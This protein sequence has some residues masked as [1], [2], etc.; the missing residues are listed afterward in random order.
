MAST[1]L[2]TT[3]GTNQNASRPTTSRKKSIVKAEDI[4]KFA[5]DES[6]IV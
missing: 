5:V 6:M 4:P 3:L 2:R 1:L